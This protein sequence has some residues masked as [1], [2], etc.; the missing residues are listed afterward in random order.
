MK[1]EELMQ[2]DWVC[3]ED[4]PTPIQVDFYKEW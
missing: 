1:A 2:F 3:L 4:D